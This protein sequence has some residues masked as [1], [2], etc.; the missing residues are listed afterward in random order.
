[1]CTILF[2]LDGT[3]VESCGELRAL[4]YD[5]PDDFANGV[6]YTADDQCLCSVNIRKVLEQKESRKWVWDPFGYKE[7][8][9]NGGL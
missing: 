2:L 7:V 8:E 3:E 5:V 6:N 1:M 4:G 9:G